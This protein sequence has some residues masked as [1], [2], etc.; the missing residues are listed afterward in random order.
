MSSSANN[1][2]RLKAHNLISCRFQ[3]CYVAVAGVP[4]RRKDHALI[5]ARFARDA[6]DKFGEV[7]RDLELRL[8]PDTAD[9]A[10]RFGMHSG[11]GEECVV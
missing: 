9:L 3:D 6:M 10:M 11:P 1:C 2:C 8:G 5:M 4:R 7:V